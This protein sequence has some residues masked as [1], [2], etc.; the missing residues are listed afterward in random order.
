MKKIKI[1]T[2]KIRLPPPSTAS[3]MKT[4]SQTKTEAETEA[5]INNNK[6]IVKN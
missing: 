4:R 2:R 1:D 5:N 3:G 6:V